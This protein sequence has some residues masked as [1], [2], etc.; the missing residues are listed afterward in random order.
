MSGNLIANRYAKALM[1]LTDTDAAA[2]DKALKFL[3]IC[4]E[5]FSLSEAKRVLKSPVMPID[6]K[7]S[8]LNFAAQKAG[9]SDFTSFAE[10]VVEAG[11]TEH[12]P[13]IYLAYRRLLD[14]KRGVAEATAVTAE[15]LTDESKKELVAVLGKIFQKKITLTSEIDKSVL[16]GVVINVGNYTIDLSLRNRLN[17]VAEFAQR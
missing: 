3:E 11:R 7:K 15:A 4:N 13:E 14:D 6:L 5:M 8:L 9:A 1:K 2:A 16:G 12:L 10:Q 17:S